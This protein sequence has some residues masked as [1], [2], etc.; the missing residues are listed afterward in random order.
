M[1][2]DGIALSGGAVAVN[3]DGALA[4]EMRRYLVLLQVVKDRRQ[5]LATLK[6]V[7]RLGPLA[8]H[9]H[10]ETGVRSEERLLTF[11]VTAVGAVG[12]GGEQLADSQAI[13]GPRPNERGGR[14]P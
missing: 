9:E 4:I 11:G 8:A 7:G 3:D 1:V 10:A 14:G 13:G 6:H 2:G 5:R 12:V